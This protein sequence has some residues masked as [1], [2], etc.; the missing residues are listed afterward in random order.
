MNSFA[1]KTTDASVHP[2]SLCVCFYLCECCSCLS[3]F[4][5]DIC[6]FLTVCLPHFRVNI[7][8][9]TFSFV[10]FFIK[11]SEYNMQIYRWVTVNSRCSNGLLYKCVSLNLKWVRKKCAF[12]PQLGV[13]VCVTVSVVLYHCWQS[14]SYHS[15]NREQRGW[16]MLA[17]C[18]T[19]GRPIISH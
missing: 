10:M 3:N 1:Q 5:C 8:W 15:P 19:V 12:V 18:P 2:L 4:V 11:L 14:S 13:C 9:L 16:H 17:W 7:K 6:C